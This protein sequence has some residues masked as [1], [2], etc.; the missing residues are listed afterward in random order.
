M[1]MALFL[2]GKTG[3]T[4]AM[5]AQ[6]EAERKRWP[7]LP[8]SFGEYSASDVGGLTIQVVNNLVAVNPAESTKHAPAP[9]AL[10]MNALSPES[11]ELHPWI[12]SNATFN[13][14]GATMPSSKDQFKQ[15]ELVDVA[16]SRG[17]FGFFVMGGMI[18]TKDGVKL[19]IKV[20]GATF[21][22]RELDKFAISLQ[23]WTQWLVHEESW[24]REVRECRPLS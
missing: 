13:W 17:M 10:V 7:F 5:F 14:V 1:A 11:A 4:H 6:A 9:H 12:P 23:R 2:T 15:I 20:Q 24:D 22:G 3:H 8:K 18:G 16:I 19:L 21:G